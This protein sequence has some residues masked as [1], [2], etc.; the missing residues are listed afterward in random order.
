[1][2][3]PAA[4]TV[5]TDGVVVLPLSP[6]PQY[7]LALAW[8]RD[9]Q[10]GAARRRLDYLRSYRDRNGWIGDR[11]MAPQRPGGAAQE[12]RSRKLAANSQNR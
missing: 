12:G 7:V 8:R 5:R 6:P 4:R 10:A 1:M 9:E 11:D 3:E 2:S